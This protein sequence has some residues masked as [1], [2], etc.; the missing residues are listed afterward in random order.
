M[1]MLLPL[2]MLTALGPALSSRGPLHA[3]R[4]GDA[5]Y[6]T[7]LGYGVAAMPTNKLQFPAQPQDSG[8]KKTAALYQLSHEQQER[9]TRSFQQAVEAGN[10]GNY[11]GAINMY[12]VVNKIFP[13]YYESHTNLAVCLERSGRDAEAESVLTRAVILFPGEYLPAD[14]LCTLQIKSLHESMTNALPSCLLALRNANNMPEAQCALHLKLASLLT[15][16]GHYDQSHVHF[17]AALALQPSNGDVLHNFAC[18]LTRASRLVE[19]GAVA[20]QAHRLNPT[21]VRHLWNRASARLYSVRHDVKA[22]ETMYQALQLFVSQLPVEK[23]LTPHPPC[24]GLKF[25]RLMSEF[26][27]S[28]KVLYSPSPIRSER[29]YQ[30]GSSASSFPCGDHAPLLFTDPEIRVSRLKNK[31]IEGEGG[32]ISDD[33]EVWSLHHNHSQNFGDLLIRLQRSKHEQS[34]QALPQADNLEVHKLDEVPVMSLIQH[35]LR[36]HFHW[37]LEA[38]PRAILGMKYFANQGITDY[39]IIFPWEAGISGVLRQSL[40]LLLGEDG[41]TSRAIFYPHQSLATF[42]RSLYVVSELYV[43][44]WKRELVAGP[45][46]LDGWSIYHAP[47]KGIQ[48]LRDAIFEAVEV[49]DQLPLHDPTRVLYVSRALATTRKVQGERLL[50]EGLKRLVGPQNLE[51]HYGNESFVDQVKM[52]HSAQL[53]IGAHGS[54]M[55]NIVWCNPSSV[56]LELPILPDLLSSGLAHIAA[57]VGLHFWTAPKVG[58]LYFQDYKIHA[59]NLGPLLELTQ[60][61]RTNDFHNASKGCSSQSS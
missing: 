17:N 50:I 9:F 22:P 54:G 29:E 25:K 32:L 1:P 61:A 7:D 26:P 57:A 20:Q 11:A 53:V 23:N 24:K 37:I 59:S 36:N 41:L 4:R 18:S 16:T 10:S 45:H 27:P 42:Q 6:S 60:W 46:E 39:Q 30:C 5:V 51:V 21:D 31:V 34:T 58:A 47:R 13:G 28:S 44:H 12:N 48:L 19:A 2:C 40:E 55:A 43:V 33:C 49:E 52:F 38:L 35:D 8:A 56:V 15:E 3:I 14:N